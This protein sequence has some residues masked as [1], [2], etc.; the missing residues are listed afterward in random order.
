MNPNNNATSPSLYENLYSSID[1]ILNSCSL[2]P[3]ITKAHHLAHTASTLI[4]KNVITAASLLLQSSTEFLSLSQ[5]LGTQTSLGSSFLLLANSHAKTAKMLSHIIAADRKI[6]QIVQSSTSTTTAAPNPT[7]LNNLLSIRAAVREG[8][9]NFHVSGEDSLSASQF[10]DMGTLRASRSQFPHT[11]PKKRV[12]QLFTSTPA[13]SPA[14]SSAPSPAPSPAPT[15]TPITPSNNAID[16]MM[17]LEQELQRL[18][19]VPSL[20]SPSPLPPLFKFPA[21]RKFFCRSE[22]EI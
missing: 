21:R 8:V 18:D 7:R 16:A 12:H 17:L 22:L 14:P 13:P 11:I 9:G 6:D 10:M 3:Q 19:A 2:L 1:P 15:L 5:Q 4:S 20:S